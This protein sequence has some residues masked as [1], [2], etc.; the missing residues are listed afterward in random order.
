MVGALLFAL[1]RC[2][3]GRKH[4]RNTAR[5]IHGW[6]CCGNVRYSKIH[7]YNNDAYYKE[8]AKTKFDLSGLIRRWHICSAAFHRRSFGALFALPFCHRKKQAASLASP[9]HAL[10]PMNFQVFPCPVDYVIAVAVDKSAMK[11]WPG[12][13]EC[14]LRLLLM[15]ARDRSVFPFTLKAI[16]RLLV[17]PDNNNKKRKTFHLGLKQRRTEA[18]SVSWMCFLKN[19]RLT[20][21]QQWFLREA[22]LPFRIK[23]GVRERR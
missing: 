23:C 22:A 2:G 9:F 1:G 8:S 16:A 17:S 11:Q 20:T 6:R 10:E 12:R 4:D 3:G 7:G 15:M 14:R 19:S 13:F 5:L 18:V 21:R